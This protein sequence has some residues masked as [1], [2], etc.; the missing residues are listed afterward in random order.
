MNWTQ[1]FTII[2]VLGAFIFWMLKQR[3]NSGK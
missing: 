1:A 3:R 2:G